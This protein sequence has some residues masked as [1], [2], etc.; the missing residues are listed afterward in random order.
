[1]SNKNQSSIDKVL[2]SID[3]DQLGEIMVGHAE[4]LQMRFSDN[5]IIIFEITLED[6]IKENFYDLQELHTIECDWDSLKD[7]LPE[8][9]VERLKK[10]FADVLTNNIEFNADETYECSEIFSALLYCDGE[11]VWSGTA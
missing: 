1:M 8:S 11:F 7:W 2:N 4:Y 9:E 10:E 5:N 6:L 3:T